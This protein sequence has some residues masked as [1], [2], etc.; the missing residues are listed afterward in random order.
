MKPFIASMNAFIGSMIAFTDAQIAFTR[1]VN[2]FTDA[3]IAFTDPAGAF[4]GSKNAFIDSKKCLKRPKASLLPS[5]RPQNSSDHP[6]TL[7]TIKYPSLIAPKP[8]R[9]LYTRQAG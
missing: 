7:K 2:A 9:I 6:S 8:T 3:R 5:W 4:I 1:P